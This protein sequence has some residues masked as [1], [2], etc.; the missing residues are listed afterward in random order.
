LLEY[1]FTLLY[2][3]LLFTA[4][5]HTAGV[6]LPSTDTTSGKYQ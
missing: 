6:S 3:E 1:T 2:L 4:R 5:E